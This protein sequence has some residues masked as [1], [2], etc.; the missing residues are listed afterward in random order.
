MTHKEFALALAV[1][2]LD[3]NDHEARI[4]GFATFSGHCDLA[5][6]SIKKRTDDPTSNDGYEA[7]DLYSKNVYMSHHNDLS[8]DAMVTEIK[9]EVLDVLLRSK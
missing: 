2:A 8:L 7:E 3:I 1:I 5:T 4:H 9:S 6:I